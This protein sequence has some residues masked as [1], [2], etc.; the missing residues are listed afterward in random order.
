MRWDDV[1]SE[2]GPV[3]YHSNV[4]PYTYAIRGCIIEPFVT[5]VTSD[6]LAPLVQLTESVTD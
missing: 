1:F 4:V 2:F 3:S 6:V 5:A